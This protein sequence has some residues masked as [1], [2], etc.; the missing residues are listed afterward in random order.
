MALKQIKNQ[1]LSI[2]SLIVMK[3]HYLRESATTQNWACNAMYFLA[4]VIK[5]LLY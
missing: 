5:P 1:K 3:C 4:I 2:I